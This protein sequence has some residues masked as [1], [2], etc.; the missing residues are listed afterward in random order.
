[1][2]ICGHLTIDS[3]TR[4]KKV[5]VKLFTKLETIEYLNVS[6]LKIDFSSASV[7]TR[8]TTSSVSSELLNDHPNVNSSEVK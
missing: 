4:K 8:I 7:C 1:M 2:L 6:F 3:F 5:F